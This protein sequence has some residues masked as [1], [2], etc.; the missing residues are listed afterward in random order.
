MK[1]LKFFI[2]S[3]AMIIAL[4]SIEANNDVQRSVIYSL[5]NSSSDIVSITGTLANKQFPIKGYFSNYGT[6]AFDW[7]Y[8]TSNSK[9][10]YKLNGMDENGYFKWINL[11]NYISSHVENGKIIIGHM[12]YN[13]NENISKI[14]NKLE[15]REF[16]IKGY[17]SNYGTG[18][19]DWI[20]KTSNS[21]GLYKLN[22]MDENGYFKWINLTENF[23]TTQVQDNKIIIG[24][25]LGQNIKLESVI[26]LNTNNMEAGRNIQLRSIIDAP[27]GINIVIVYKILPN[28]V[29]NNVTGTYIASDRFVA[30]QSRTI[31]ELNATL[32]SSLQS[33]TYKI[34]AVMNDNDAFAPDYNLSTAQTDQ[35]T[36]TE[37]FYV[38]ANDGKPD[39]EVI[40][41][42]ISTNTNARINNR[43]ITSE[44][45]TLITFD[46]GVVKGKVILNSRGISLDGIVGVQDYIAKAENFKISACINI[47][48]SCRP[49]EMYSVDETNQTH[50]DAF[51]TVKSAEPGDPKTVVFNGIIRGQLLNDIA[52][53]TMEDGNFTTSIKVLIGGIE[54]SSTQ[55]PQRNSSS[56]AVKFS[57]VFLNQ[58]NIDNTN[59]RVALAM[60]NY[61]LSMKSYIDKIKA[62]DP[63]YNVQ[64]SSGGLNLFNPNLQ[65]TVTDP[66]EGIAL[67]Q[68]NVHQFTSEPIQLR[69][70]VEPS[71]IK[72]VPPMIPQPSGIN[73]KNDPINNIQPVEDYIAYLTMNAT[74][75]P[76]WKKTIENAELTTDEVSYKYFGIDADIPLMLN[77][78]VGLKGNIGGYAKFDF[79]GVHFLGYG[80][81]KVYL[82]DTWYDFLDIEAR[83]QTTP[84]NLEHTG[85]SFQL[86]FL[87]KTV[88]EQSRYVT[89]GDG[90]FTSHAATLR[91]RIKE[92]IETLE[93][94]NGDIL[95]YHDALGWADGYDDGGT[96]WASGIPIAYR[97]GYEGQLGVKMDLDIKSLGRID[98]AAT[99]YME[100]SGYGSGGIGI[101][102]YGFGV[103]VGIEGDLQ[104]ID[105]KLIC[106]GSAGITFVTGD[107][108]IE[109]YIGELHENITNEFIG[110]NGGVYVYAK[111]TLL[112]TYKH[113][114]ADFDT[115][116]STKELLDKHQTLFKVVLP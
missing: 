87:E 91:E 71:N 44:T 24:D 47:G 40:S 85:Y 53:K 65:W 30:N 110:P 34:V 67:Q 56:T 8:K 39:L 78:D 88:Y 46:V 113:K 29:D 63:T 60:S 20:Y 116:N 105:E 66:I 98:A 94:I 75:S 62:I 114:I 14:V 27:D 68:Q 100:F 11:T 69:P 15:N 36:S 50:Y 25:T 81:I 4:V 89:D 74:I 58:A 49:I 112:G 1:L 86:G 96:F 19:F 115:V 79:G 9:G 101:E 26:C 64:V 92:N 52:N 23:N 72:M 13:G 45:P 73:K 102:Y 5:K 28:G 41:F 42:K 107:K 31:R 95:S 2:I 55:I 97:Y 83:Q 77:N 38:Q 3:L 93:N 32:P 37:P 57:P 103:S 7:I 22:G 104:L 84:G 43:S 80:G 12:Q 106:G 54:E 10:L 111:A 109:S 21:K 61:R 51:M 33:G 16:P 90:I 82:I 35:S 48:D 17:F 99:P 70:I 59:D 108:G 6:G 76:A 18:A